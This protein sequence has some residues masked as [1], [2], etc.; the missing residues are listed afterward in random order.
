MAATAND[1]ST[2]A[3][4]QNALADI[5]FA[6]I[7]DDDLTPSEDES[8]E[9]RALQL[10]SVQ[11]A[12]SISI[13][14]EQTRLTSPK[15][16]AAEKAAALDQTDGGILFEGFEDHIDTTPVQPPITRVPSDSDSE[17]VNAVSQ[18]QVRPR[19]GQR[20]EPQPRERLPSPWRAG[21]K[22]FHDKA[23][24]HRS[25]L[26]QTLQS[27]RRRASSGGSMGD[28]VRK[29]MPFSFPSL[30]KSK[31]LHFS[32][33]SFSAF[34]LDGQTTP[35][36]SDRRRRGTFAY[37]PSSGSIPQGDGSYES[38]VQQQKRASRGTMSPSSQSS[39]API[40]QREFGTD[41][42]STIAPPN[43]RP[44]SE[45]PTPRLRRSNSEGSL[46]VYRTKSFASSLGDDSR[47]E[48]VQEQVNN[49]MKAIRDSWQDANFK[50]P[51]PNLPNFNFSYRDD[52]FKPRNG[53][54]SQQDGTTHKVS[55]R[56]Q[57][58]PS[59]TA[60]RSNAKRPSLAT[61]AESETQTYFAQ[62]LQELEGDLVVLG[63]YRG[64]ILRSASATLGPHQSWS[65]SP[66]SRSGSP[67]RSRRR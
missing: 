34:S 12:I 38:R 21:P 48:S 45:R 41:S 55:L 60:T 52:L 20:R 7:A 47:F 32:L 62:A 23:S 11:S 44:S 4:R 46:L 42:E 16:P 5:Q 51:S 25:I 54:V 27:G 19:D 59:G 6:S 22:T 1:P 56:A 18:R 37:A 29:Y 2:H 36:T 9:E 24:D 49:R 40:P 58:A 61:M 53:S 13:G 39:T 50:F 43:V 33:P 26:R 10:E 14:R 64:S 57:D 30:P 3:R 8:P 28:T 67:F 31:D 63:G 17:D 15:T 66:E 35:S 65:E